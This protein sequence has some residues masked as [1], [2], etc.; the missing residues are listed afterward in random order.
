M[1]NHTSNLLEIKGDKSE[2]KRLIKKVKSKESAFD[3]NKIIP[4]PKSLAITSGSATDYGVAVLN[5]RKNGDD[6]KLKEVLTYIW[7]KEKNITT[8]EDLAEYLV[9]NDIAN[10]KEGQKSINN[11]RMAM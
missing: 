10:L 1:P 3:F 7:V 5:F 2:I 9:K 6:S 8:V 11:K 4:M